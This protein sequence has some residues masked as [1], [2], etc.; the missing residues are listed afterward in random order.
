MIIILI[1]NTSQAINQDFD[2]IFQLYISLLL[3]K[4]EY[5]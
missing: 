4:K 2:I 1:N 3:S 5:S